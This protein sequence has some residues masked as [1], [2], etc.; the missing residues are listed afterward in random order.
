MATCKECLHYDACVGTVKAS[1]PNIQ[2]KKIEQV[3][4]RENNC[5]NFKSASDVVEVVRC[6]DCV[7][8]T[9]T[10]DGEYDTHDIVCGYFM[11]DG[12]DGNDFCSYGKK[13]NE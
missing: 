2:E 13:E 9:V 6:K 4:I 8:K 5:K 10:I 1:F 3:G 12:F 11:S 7:Y